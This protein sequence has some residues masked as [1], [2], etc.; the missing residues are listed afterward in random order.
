MTYMVLAA[1]PWPVVDAY[2]VVTNEPLK[3][4][5]RIQ[6]AVRRVRLTPDMLRAVHRERVSK[7]Q[8]PTP[9]VP[10]DLR[11]DWQ[12]RR[13]N[14]DQLRFIIAGASGQW[15]VPASTKTKHTFDA[16]TSGPA[17]LPGL[18]RLH[19]TASNI[20]V[21]AACAFA[22]DFGRLGF[23]ELNQNKPL[24]ISLCVQRPRS[25]QQ[26]Y[27]WFSAG[28]PLAWMLTHARTIDIALNLIRKL[29]Q[30]DREGLRR[31]L[32]GTE[33]RHVRRASHVRDLDGRRVE[34]SPASWTYL[35]LRVATIEPPWYVGIELDPI[36][37][38][39]R[40]RGEAVAAWALLGQLVNPNLQRINADID[41]HGK[42]R[43]R[44]LALIQVAYQYI[45]D[46]IET[47]RI[48]RCKDPK[49]QAPFFQD[50]ASQ[51]YCPPPPGS[52]RGS[53]CGERHRKERLRAK[54]H[55]D[56]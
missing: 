33:Q 53:R 38:L 9:S 28:D 35:P 6:K 3:E 52:T 22:R 23:S 4:I 14:G 30:H 37:Q 50:H 31:L 34:W 1:L 51:E 46:Q 10:A 25:L 13:A 45:A 36:R 19:R 27:S 5:S 40:K 56:Q 16:S 48:R 42:R 11:G 26:V 55:K 21:A 15:I 8:G 18:V 39:L 12:T 43:H 32:A 24:H 29:Q 2:E 41:E 17:I 54:G 47:G 49:C 7:P 20:G 44:P